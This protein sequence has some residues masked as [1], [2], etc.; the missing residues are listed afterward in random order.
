MN[1]VITAVNTLYLLYAVANSDNQCKVNFESM[2]II[3]NSVQPHCIQSYLITPNVT[4]LLILI[5]YKYELTAPQNR[6]PTIEM[7]SY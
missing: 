2:T 4:F 3:T 5:I 6:H 7:I 1:V